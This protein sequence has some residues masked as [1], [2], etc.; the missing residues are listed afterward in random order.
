MKNT[1]EI[2]HL[3]ISCHLLNYRFFCDHICLINFQTSLK[4]K[5]KNLEIKTNVK[6]AMC[7][8]TLIP[9][10]SGVTHSHEN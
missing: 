1:A 8:G 3:S 4:T 10:W 9:D 6:I 2:V 5:E 7:V